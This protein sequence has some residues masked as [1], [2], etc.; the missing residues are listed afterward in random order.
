MIQLRTTTVLSDSKKTP[1]SFATSGV[2][3][4]GPMSSLTSFKRPI[5][6][7]GMT[8]AA[9]ADGMPLM[10]RCAESGVKF[11]QLETT[12]AKATP[13]IARPNLSIVCTAPILPIRLRLSNQFKPAG[14]SGVSA[15]SRIMCWANLEVGEKSQRQVA[16]LRDPLPVRL[17]APVKIGD[18]LRPLRRVK[19]PNY[20]RSVEAKT[21]GDSGR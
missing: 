12:T 16:R 18:G 1:V 14:L 13:A 19:S 2:Q 8:T 5:T 9:S 4:P 7:V 21:P 3:V 11:V 10:V 17:Q 20:G 6:D 15:S